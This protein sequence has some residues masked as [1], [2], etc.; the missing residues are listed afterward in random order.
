MQRARPEFACIFAPFASNNAG[1]QII[2]GSG[3]H[4]CLQ[5]L[6]FFA[7]VV[8]FF[9]ASVGE[10]PVVFGNNRSAHID[11]ALSRL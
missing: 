5:F 1:V 10:S 9:F 8:L 6:F 2:I 3:F 7:S 11:F 4:Y